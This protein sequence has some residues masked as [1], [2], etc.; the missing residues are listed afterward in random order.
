MIYIL[1]E[2]EEKKRNQNNEFGEG[3]HKYFAHK[4]TSRDGDYTALYTA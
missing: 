3:Y 1:F 2:I 4:N